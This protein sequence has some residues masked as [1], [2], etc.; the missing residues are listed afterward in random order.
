M[1]LSV[2]ALRVGV[3]VASLRFITR[4]LARAD[5]HKRARPAAEAGAHSGAGA[6]VDRSA[7]QRAYRGACNRAA[8]RRIGLRGSHGLPADCFIGILPAAAI[9]LTEHFVWLAGA[10]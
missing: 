1:A 9:V 6:A 3:V 2:H 5:A 8:H 4:D 7:D 10:R